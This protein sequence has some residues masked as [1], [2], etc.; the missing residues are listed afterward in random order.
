MA[1]RLH[2]AEDEKRRKEKEERKK[3]EE[4]KKMKKEVEDQSGSK[5]VSLPRD[6]PAGGVPDSSPLQQQQQ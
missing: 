3:M 1:Y 6:L 5:V 4:E 2:A